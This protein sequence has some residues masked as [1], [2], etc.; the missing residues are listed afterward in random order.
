MK[1]A[2]L[3][4][5]LRS[6]ILS[7]AI[8]VLLFLSPLILLAQV[9][10]LGIY[11]TLTPGT[12]FFSLPLPLFFLHLIP[13]ILSLSQPSH[14]SALALRSRSASASSQC[15]PISLDS[16]ELSGARPPRRV[17]VATA[18]FSF[19]DTDTHF[20]RRCCFD[21]SPFLFIPLPRFCF[22]QSSSDANRLHSASA[23]SA[24]WTPDPR[25]QSLNPTS[26]QGVDSTQTTYRRPT[27]SPIPPRASPVAAIGTDQA[28]NQG[29]REQ[30]LPTTQAAA[31]LSIPRPCFGSSRGTPA[32]C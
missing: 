15:E 29:S 14:T 3:G 31:A 23:I 16:S 26:V 8:L 19:L 5:P 2:R 4:C 1:I 9:V 25:G 11:L 12:C 32:P 27:S 17:P 20:N 22:V 13:S 21:I 24:R 7:S 18:R 10:Y 30:S 28:A 6:S